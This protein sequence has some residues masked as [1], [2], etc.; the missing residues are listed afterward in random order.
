MLALLS[1]AAA[2]DVIGVA[3]ASP[4]V[5]SLAAHAANAGVFVVVRALALVQRRR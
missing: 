2:V 4:A 5:A 1:I 3:T